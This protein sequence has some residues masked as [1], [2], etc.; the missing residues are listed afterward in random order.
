MAD[1]DIAELD[2]ERGPRR[3]YPEAVYCEGKSV[4]QVREIVD[5]ESPSFDV[6]QSLAVVDVIERQFR[7]TGLD[8]AIEVGDSI[9]VHRQRYDLLTSRESVIDLLGQRQTYLQV[10]AATGLTV[11]QVRKIERAWR[12]REI[13]ERQRCLPLE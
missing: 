6:S 5:V 7:G 9:M 11:S 8:L 10:S 1:D 3:G 12:R 2:F 13:E 4:D